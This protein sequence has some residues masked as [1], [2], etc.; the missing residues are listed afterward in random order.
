LENLRLGLGFKGR[1]YWSKFWPFRA[2]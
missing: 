1:G 2:V